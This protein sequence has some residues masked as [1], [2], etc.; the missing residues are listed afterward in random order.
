MRSWPTI[1]TKRNAQPHECCKLAL[2]SC[3]CLDKAFDKSAPCDAYVACASGE[4]IEDRCCPASPA[5]GKAHFQLRANALQSF[6][7]H[8][9]LLL[10]TA[11]RGQGDR[12]VND[13][14]N[15]LGASSNKNKSLGRELHKRPHGNAMQTETHSHTRDKGTRRKDT[16]AQRAD[17][18][19]ALLDGCGDKAKPQAQRRQRR[20]ECQKTASQ[21]QRS[22]D[23]SS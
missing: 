19:H 17:T 12:R 2:S 22:L 20:K 21:P 6:G 5:A 11:R 4:A 13:S 3:I 15:G 9:I 23:S 1:A 14:C 7:K 18:H 10:A 8:C 16:L